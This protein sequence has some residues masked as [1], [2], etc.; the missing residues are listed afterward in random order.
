MPLGSLGAC[1]TSLQEPWALSVQKNV[2]QTSRQ[3]RLEDLGL[4]YDDTIVTQSARTVDFNGQAVVPRYIYTDLDK[5]DRDLTVQVAATR[6]VF[7]LNPDMTIGLTIPYVNKE[8]RRTN[9]TSGMRETL[10]ADGLGD[11]AVTGKYRFFQETGPGE[12]TEAAALFGLELPTG[13]TD[14]TDG[15]MRLAQPLQPGSGSVDAIL[16]AAFTRVDGRWLLNA[17]LLGK[18]NSE[19]DDYRFGNMYRFD[20]GGQFRLYPSRYTSFDQTTVNL[21]AELNTVYAERDDVDGAAVSDSG[22][23]KAFATPGLQVIVSESVLFEAAVQI[24]VYRDLNGS[25]LEENF[26]TILGMRVRF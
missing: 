6:V 1:V 3:K 24:P 4:L 11:V 18:F 7:G 8:L 20:V 10:R 17:D 22:G 5:G 26:R 15:G 25:Q 13:R 16:G 12:T 19:A 23:F 14:V 9:P 2:D 21:V